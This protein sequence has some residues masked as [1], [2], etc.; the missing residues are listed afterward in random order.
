MNF[1]KTLSLLL[2][3]LGVTLFAFYNVTDY[4]FINWDDH[5][6]VVSNPDIAELSFNSVKKIFSSY[7]V[8]MYQP[9]TTLSYAMDHAIYGVRDS[10]GFHTTSLILHLLNI[11]FLF[12]FIKRLKFSDVQA[13]V[14]VMFFAVHPIQVEAVSWVS[15]RSTLMF[16]MFYILSLLFY[17]CYAEKRRFSSVSASFLFFLL[18]VLSKPSAAVF[19]LMIPVLE[20]WIYGKMTLKT[21]FRTCIFALPGIFIL[22]ITYFSRS[23]TGQISSL[24]NINFL[25]N[26]GFALWS[27]MVYIFQ[28]IFPFKQNVYQIYPDFNW[29]MIIIPM[30]FFILWMYFYITMKNNRKLLLMS[31]GMFLIPLSVH[32]KI[33]PFGDQY[34]A[35]RYAYLSLPG[36]FI[37][38][39][40]VL[41]NFS[42]QRKLLKFIFFMLLVLIALFLAGLS[43]MRK[44]TWKNSITLWTHVIENNTGHNI[45]YYNR[46]NAYRDKGRIMESIK[47][48]SMVIEQKPDYADAYFARGS[49]YSGIKDYNKAVEDYNIVIKLKPEVYQAYYNRGNAFYNSGN[50]TQAVQDYRKFLESEPMH[51]QASF[52]MILSMIQL[53]YNASELLDSLNIF[54]RKF[55]ENP[56]GYYLRGIIFLEKNKKLACDNFLISAKLGNSD[57]ESFARKY[58]Y[59]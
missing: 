20:Y 5:V 25:N 17:V 48:F 15:A 27:V 11:V 1:F 44:D 21:L 41:Q 8:G 29:Y 12:I 7:Y 42:G 18:A 36:L 59:D 52:Y 19:F 40:S 43:F 39:V 32:L 37:L 14:L 28:I 31:A 50:F 10:G 45:A 38:P 3:I 16:S 51:E 49:L 23:D 6:Q 34:M 4:E 54:V 30:V 24:Q 2:I 58:C 26:L 9:L 57:A 22:V 55:P 53:N 56:D 13:F 35:D 47:D 46:G 33:I